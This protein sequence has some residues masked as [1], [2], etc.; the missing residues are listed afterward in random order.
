[1]SFL[2]END[3]AL[4]SASKTMKHQYNYKGDTMTFTNDL[5][6]KIKAA[7]PD[8]TVRRF[9]RYCGMSDGYYGSVTAQSLPLSTNA[10]IH[11]AEVLTHMQQIKPSHALDAALAMIADEVA[12]RMQSINSSS[13]WAVRQMIV[14]AVAKVQV[15][16]VDSDLA[17]LPIVLG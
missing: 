14:K 3:I 11:L 17:P 7:V 8:M 9:S 1:M 12:R 6:G 16:R 10:L 4:A 2:E 15:N 13:N 5:Y